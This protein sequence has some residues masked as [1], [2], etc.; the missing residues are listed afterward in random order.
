MF[1]IIHFLLYPASNGYNSY[2]DK[3]VESIGALENPP[4]VY[5]E[6]YWVSMVLDG[7]AIAL[8]WLIRWEVGVMLAV[9][10]LISKAYSHPQIRLKK[11]PIIG[12]LAAGL[13]Q[14][15][16]TFFMVILGTS[17]LPRW[18]LFTPE[19]IIPAALSTVLLWGSYPMTQ[20]YQHGEDARRGDRTLS[21][22][23]G[24]KGTFIFTAL[25]FLLANLGFIYYFLVYQQKELAIW[26]QVALVPVFAY[27]F[28]WQRSA[29]IDPIKADFKRTMYLN[30]IS[31]FCLNI[32]FGWWL[33]WQ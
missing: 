17:D 24:I 18:E 25:V 12:W 3:D 33:L 5:L 6:L 2:F 23:L 7:L 4:P 30:F 28:W 11:M 31:A 22:I 13:F 27:F 8:G 21:L 26:F 16:F 1:L 14:G 20:V 29:F 10:G 9:Y 32:F 15:A 19:L